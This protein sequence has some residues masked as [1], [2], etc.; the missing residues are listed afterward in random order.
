MDAH[1]ITV[2]DQ[3][4]DRVVGNGILHHLD[5]AAAMT[6]IHRISKPSAKAIFQEPLG[7]NMLMKLY[8]KIAGVHTSDERPLTRVARSHPTNWL[9]R[10]ASGVEDKL[11]NRHVLDH[12]NRFAVLVYETTLG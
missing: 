6:E 1:K 5:L 3:F 12:W 8:R 10:A 2:P 9:L 7:D 4:F 11:N